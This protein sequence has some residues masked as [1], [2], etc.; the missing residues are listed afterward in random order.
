M[1]GLL[2]GRFSIWP[3]YRIKLNFILQDSPK[4]MKYAG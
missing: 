1:S 2:T 3:A 4:S